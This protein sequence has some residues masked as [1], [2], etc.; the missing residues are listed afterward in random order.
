MNVTTA[1]EL[2]K[3]NGRKLVGVAAKHKASKHFEGG[4]L[5]GFPATQ[6]SEQALLLTAS[7]HHLPRGAWHIIRSNKGLDRNKNLEKSAV[8]V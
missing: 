4:N 1:R 5:T 3:R 7:G 6:P 8:A 2:Y